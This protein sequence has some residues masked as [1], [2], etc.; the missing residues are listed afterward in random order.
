MS[1]PRKAP[2]PSR[3][4]PRKEAVPYEAPTAD[5]MRHGAFL[6]CVQC[7]KEWPLRLA[8]PKARRCANCARESWRSKKT[9]PVEREPA[10]WP[11]KPKNGYVPPTAD[12]RKYGNFLHCVECERDW[13]LQ[14]TVPSL[15]RCVNCAR[16]WWRAQK[17][18]RTGH[19][20]SKYG[21]TPTDVLEMLSEQSSRCAIC[22]K[23]ITA[24]KCHVDHDH[25]TGAI[26]G[27]LCKR[28]NCSIGHFDEDPVILRMAATYIERHRNKPSPTRPRVMRTVPKIPL[29]P[30]KPFHFVTRDGER[31]DL[32]DPATRDR[33]ATDTVLRREMDA[34][35]AH[36]FSDKSKSGR[37]PNGD[38]E[39]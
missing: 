32:K 9:D 10:D 19:R 35:W 34:F 2:K 15:D 4:R 17:T 8:V 3:G 36:K 21:L 1:T 11:R 37:S 24:E 27:L 18:E 5:E 28:C 30:K 23:A 33:L 38:D 7:E 39:S 20:W 6:R 26:R 12:D 25:S 29:R 22:S 14:F 31:I 13:P 16:D